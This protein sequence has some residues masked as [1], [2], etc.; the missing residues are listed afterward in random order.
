[1]AAKHGTRRRYVEGCRCDDCADAQRNYQ[2]DYRERKAN[3]LP[4]VSQ[5]PRPQK[6]DPDPELSGPGPVESGVQAEIAGL[7]EARPG[8]AEAALALARIMDNPKATNQK[9]AAAKVLVTL[10]DKLRAASSGGR[11]GNLALVRTMTKGD[12]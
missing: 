10:L 6:A 12:A 2:R 8:L 7:N 3:G 4:A 11:R 9:A 5:L 1:M